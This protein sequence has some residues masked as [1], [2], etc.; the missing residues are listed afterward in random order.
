MKLN[1]Y[2]CSHRTNLSD[3]T[4]RSKV[5]NNVAQPNAEGFSDSQQRINRD[6]PLCPFHLTDVN[7]MKVGFLSQFLLAES[8]LLTVQSNILAN[9]TAMFWRTNHSPLP[10]QQAPRRS[11]KLPALDCSRVLLESGIQPSRNMKEKRKQ[12]TRFLKESV[13]PQRS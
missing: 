12:P 4:E 11:H 2:C 6:C 3:H 8:G 7:G 9:Q 13:S 1:V 5:A 10:K